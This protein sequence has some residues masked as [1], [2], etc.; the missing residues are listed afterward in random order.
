M[1]QGLQ[2]FAA[3]IQNHLS[4]YLQGQMM[5]SMAN[6]KPLLFNVNDAMQ[7][8]FSRQLP[9]PNSFKYQRAVAP[10]NFGPD[11]ATPSFDARSSM[12]TPYSLR[13]TSAANSA[14]TNQLYRLPGIT[15]WMR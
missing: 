2:N 1:L 6:N 14:G 4:P 13:Q 12:A 3:S 11:A 10:S 9:A 8:M 7:K 5:S 15:G